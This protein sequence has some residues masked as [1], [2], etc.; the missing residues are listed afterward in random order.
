MIA[1][2]DWA[3]KE[4]KRPKD[5]SQ[6]YWEVVIEKENCRKPWNYELKKELDVKQK[7]KMIG[8][9][10]AEQEHTIGEVGSTFTIQGFDLN[11]ARVIL[12]ESVKYRD[13]KG[14]YIYACD[15]ELRET[16]IKAM[17]E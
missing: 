5:G 11:Y 1:N 17:K 7:R 4:G 6:K 2:C 8:Q 10:W 14:L 9:A 15:D 13:G 12:G 16:L 3:Y